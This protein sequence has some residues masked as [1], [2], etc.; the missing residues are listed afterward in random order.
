MIPHKGRLPLIELQFIIIYQTF[1]NFIECNQVKSVFPSEN[2]PKFFIS[3]HF[4]L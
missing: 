3:P 4:K 1:R 2:Y